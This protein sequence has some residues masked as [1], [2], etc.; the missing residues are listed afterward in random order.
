MNF[1]FENRAGRPF[2]QILG[3][4]AKL[5]EEQQ[6]YSKAVEYLALLKQ[7]SPNKDFIQKWIDELHARRGGVK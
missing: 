3:N 2:A 1:P 6:N 4:L 7:V 5:E